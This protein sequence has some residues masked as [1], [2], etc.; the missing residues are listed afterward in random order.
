M[1]V[2]VKAGLD[3]D[4]V[5][6]GSEHFGF[7]LELRLIRRRPPVGHVAV[8]VKEAALVVEAMGHLMAD[9]DTDAAV[10]DGVIRI[11]VEERRLQDGGREADLIGRRV[12]V[13]IDR[14]RR[15]AP[16]GLVRRL[17]E[18]G[19]IV[20]HIPG[21]GTAQI[22]KIGLGRIDVEGAVI[23]PLVGIADLDGEGCELLMR[24]D[25]GGVAHPVERINVLAKGGTQVLHEGDHLLLGS[26]REI[27]LDI[28]LA[29]GFA[30]NAVRD[31]HRPLP[32]GFLLLGPGH[33][34][35]EEVPGSGIEVIAQGS[36]G[37]LDKLPEH[38][39]LQDSEVGIGEDVIESFEERRLA[40]DDLLLR[41]NVPSLEVLVEE[42][43]G[44]GRNDRLRRHRIVSSL[45][46]P[47]LDPCPG[48][49][50]KL[51]LHGERIRSPVG[52]IV[53]PGEREHLL[54]ESLITGFESGTGF[55]QIV[56]AVAHAEPALPQIEDL[57]VAVHQVSFDISAEEAAV[58]AIVFHFGKLC[59]KVLLAFNR[60]DLCDIR[61][62]RLRAEGIAGGGIQRHLVQVGDLLVDGPLL[63]PHLGHADEELIEPLLVQLREHVE[64]AI[65]GEL[66]LERVLRLPAAGGILVEINLGADGRVKIG[67]VDRLH[68]L[69]PGTAS[70]QHQNRGHKQKILFHNME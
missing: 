16:F 11:G 63:S 30:E 25:L 56:I 49:L 32:T 47:L 38:I 46:I 33:L 19:H 66:G 20:G 57:V 43:G 42:Y 51:I 64:R 29:D 9:H 65:S 62:N 22:L 2:G 31:A 48:N 60:K 35:A 39:V 45:E 3:L 61:L 50:C 18:F 34:A 13:G 12:I 52:R 54:K 10:I 40:D 58:T 41:G 14:L 7:L 44:I 53:D 1:A 27:A 26:L 55:F 6:L 59:D 5:E 8:R 23:L 36:G 70:S 37:M 21:A 69:P 68:H 24:L 4:R 28:H 67:E 15:H 17:A